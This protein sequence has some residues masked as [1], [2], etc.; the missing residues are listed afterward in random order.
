MADLPPVAELFCAGP[1]SS[2]GRRSGC[3]GLGRAAAAGVKPRSMASGV[4]R[5]RAGATQNRL[6]QALDRR[7]IFGQGDHGRRPARRVPVI[8]APIPRIWG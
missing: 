7:R 6:D 1:E 5:A 2:V 8:P 4:D 3:Y